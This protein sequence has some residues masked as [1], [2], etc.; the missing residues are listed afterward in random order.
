MLP[1]LLA[2]G[3]AE[4]T[5]LPWCTMSV[6]PEV[7]QNELHSTVARSMLAWEVASP[8]ADLDLV[9]MQLCGEP[10]AGGVQFILGDLLGDLGDGV[11]SATWASGAGTIVLLNPASFWSSDAEIA[12]GT[13]VERPSIDRE[14]ARYTGQLLGVP[15]L[16][17]LAEGAEC[18]G[19]DAQGVMAIP[20][21]ELCLPTLFDA[22]AVRGLADAGAGPFTFVTSLAAEG[23]ALPYTT[24]NEVTFDATTIDDAGIGVEWSFGDGE[25]SNDVE[26]CHEYT[27]AGQ[28]TQ[29]LRL[30][31]PEECGGWEEKEAA[32]ILACGPP[33]PEE[34]LD[35]GFSIEHNDGLTYQI[36]NRMDVSVYGCIDSARWTVRELPDGTEEEVAVAWAPKI[37]FEHEGEYRITGYIGGAGGT[38]QAYMDIT[39]EDRSADAAGCASGAGAP[40]VVAAAAA[41]VLALGRRRQN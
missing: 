18:W 37:T 13:C 31:W 38:Y 19:Y 33:Q 8:C 26:V 41:V 6:D 28:F 15:E 1:I 16:D 35:F 5:T 10:P 3:L 4:A 20:G 32:S 12:A 29:V 9:D 14:I 11:Y 2:V 30:T 40:G 39:A 34:G 36:T 24:C 27:V 22:Y 23:G 21:T 25:A 17:C 7:S